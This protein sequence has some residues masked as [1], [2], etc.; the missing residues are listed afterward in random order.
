MCVRRGLRRALIAVA[1]LAA[2]SGPRAGAQSMQF[3]H[4]GVDDGLPSSLVSDIARDRRGVM[5]IGTA[6]GVSR[7]DGHRFRTY[8]HDRA[9][10]NSLPVG[11]VAQVYEDQGGT[12]WVV[13]PGGLSRYDPA[14]DGF[15][16]Y[17]SAATPAPGAHTIAG[18]V[19]SVLGAAR[20]TLWVGT[21]AGLYAFDPRTGI[22]TPHPL[23][24]APSGGP[25]SPYVLALYRDRAARVWVGTRSGLYE[26]DAARAGAV[27]HFAPDPADASS[28]PDT[29]IRALTEDAAGA[30][31]VGTGD[32]GLARLD[33]RTNRFT[34]FRHDPTDPHSLAKDRVVRLIPDRL[35]AGLWVG[36]E[37]G[38]LDYLDVATGHFAHHQ[39]DPNTP[40]GIGSNSI[41]SVYQDTTGV[42]W[43]GTFTGGLDVSEP[44]RPAIQHYHAVAGDSTSLSYNAVP[45]FG[46]DR[47]GYLW[48]ATD[49]GGLNRLDPATGRFAR[50]TPRNTN[51]NAEAVLGVVED[52]RGALWVATWGGGISRFDRTRRRFR[53]YSTANSDIPSDN[54]YEILEDRAGQL[55]IGTEN[56]VV[57]MFDRARGAFTRRFA[58]VP[59][60]L[61]PSSVLVLRELQ[62]GRFAIGLREGGVTILDPTTGAQRHYVAAGEAGARGGDLASNRVR[63]LLE[64]EPGVLWVGTEDGLDRLVLGTGRST[65]FDRH[66]GL[67]SDIV[68]GLVADSAGR[69]WVSTDHGLGRFDPERRTF[70]HFERADGLQGSEF[71]MRSAFRAHDG[72]L[73]FGGNNGFNAVHPGRV[74][75]HPR[76]PDVALTGLQLF[77][78]PVAVGAPGSPLTRAIGETRTLTLTAAQNVVTFEFA[79]P[80]YAVPEKTRYAYRLD[81][82]DPEWQDVGHQH[83]ASYTN[84]AP[85]HYTFRARASV[86]DGGW[87][88]DGTALEVIVTPPMWQTWWFRLLVVG[89]GL[90]AFYRFARFQQQ[91]RLEIALGQQA[92]R[93]SL[94]GLANR[95]LFRDRVEH[96]LARLAREGPPAAGAGGQVAVLFLDLDNFKS[97]NDSFGHHAG[98]C[99]LRAVS[100]RLLNATRGCDTV[101][102]FGGDEFAVLIENARGAADA[103]AVSERIVAAMRAP[104]PLSSAPDG[105]TARVGVSVGIAFA[106]PGLDADAL[107]RHADAAMYQA[108]AD[109]KGRH[110]VFDPALVAAAA[111]RLDLERD[112]ADALVDG[113]SPGGQFAL[114]YQPIVTLATGAIVSAEALVRWRHP[115]RGLVGPVQFIPL[116]EASGLIVALGRWVLEEACRT[117]AAWPAAADGAPLGVTVNVSARQLLHAA[118]PRHVADALAASGLA[119]ARLTLEIT[120][121]VLM[122]DTDATLATLH[123]LKALGVRLAV[124]DFG[125]GYSS[126]RYLQRFPV[127]V[128]KI[129]KSFVDGLAR[130]PQDA[131]LARTIVALGELLELRTVAEGVEHAPQRDQLIAMGC[132]LGQ[133]YLFSR[134]VDDAALRGLLGGAP[135]VGGGR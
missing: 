42:L 68:L 122:Q 48:V 33:A 61:D 86:G 134:P 12:L 117:A 70:V 131:A 71:L 13:T 87:S 41:W 80:D 74:V 75:D 110:S 128:L 5:W 85:G 116:A 113:A 92:L 125:T 32:G 57:A 51:L 62:D 23:A 2:G 84:L 10:P 63:A 21:S 11:V 73:Y 7:Y 54:V 1:L 93:D 115:T 106:T 91:R 49:G 53:P 60:G 47:A 107:L 38:G 69:L 31:W 6:H 35:G 79:A 25:A 95:A 88:G 30:L 114:L 27:R 58:V 39:F 78:R 16:T 9:D 127:D 112:L 94:T 118:L 14:R 26:L 19:T 89:A 99:L 121:G 22:A 77:N 37:N 3:R 43:V 36:T 72:T 67:P 8:A 44:T 100:T 81:G 59:P 103:Q 45:G 29:N 40:S 98:D 34:R 111:D 56:A 24:A 50:Y 135:G 64:T 55:W 52:H 90:L 76:A 96:A 97:V 18:T 124:D 105:S 17:P 129:D 119:P 82:F 20:G 133:G 130:G 109:G 15:V 28:L 123:T 83:T 104:V 102:R 108:K 65:H 120:E 126:L 66:D 132:E 101:A 46:E 4:I